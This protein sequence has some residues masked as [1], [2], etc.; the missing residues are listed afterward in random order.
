MLL[1]VGGYFAA[2]LIDVCARFSGEIVG[3][4]EGTEN[5]FRR[6]LDLEKPPCPIFS[7]A[8]SPLKRPEDYLVGQSIVFSTEALMRSRGD[9]LH[10]REACV[11]GF[12]KLGSSI[13]RTLHT[14]N[15]RVTV[16][17]DDPIRMAQV[18]SQGFRVADSRHDARE[19]GELPTRRIG[20]S[21]HLPRT[22]RN[23][24]SPFTSSR[25]NIGSGIPRGV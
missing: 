23:T 13:A 9:I 16:Y 11:I 5:G 3:V 22:S 12:G 21:V 6:Y 24:C 4:V 17:D 18:M 2:T 14:K 8:R 7:V 1:D 25:G 15:V 19:R 10:G 20:G